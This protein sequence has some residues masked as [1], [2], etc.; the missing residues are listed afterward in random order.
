M[1]D[2]PLHNMKLKLVDEDKYL[3]QYRQDTVVN[4]FM[5]NV[6]A[7]ETILGQ[8]VK[9]NT[10]MNRFRYLLPNSILKK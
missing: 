8:S 3:E 7:I 5:T 9:A 10:I 4:I 1:T 6:V 2:I